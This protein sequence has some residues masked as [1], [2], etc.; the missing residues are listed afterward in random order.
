M[1]LVSSDT[2]RGACRVVSLAFDLKGVVALPG[3]QLAVQFLCRFQNIMNIKQVARFA[4]SHAGLRVIPAL[5]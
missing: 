3:G 4:P 5:V 1:V 2:E